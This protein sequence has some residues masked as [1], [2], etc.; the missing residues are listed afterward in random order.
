MKRTAITVRH[1]TIVNHIACF[2]NYAGGLATVE[3]SELS[4][5]TRLRPDLQ[6]ILPGATY[7]SDVKV[8][9]SLS[10]SHVENHWKNQLGAAK[11]GEKEKTKKYTQLA[12]QHHMEFAPF[13]TET[14]GGI[15][16]VSEQ[17]L[18]NIISTCA[19]HQRI[20]EPK[21]VRRELLGAI[22]IAIQKGNASAMFEGYYRARRATA[23]MECPISG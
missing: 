7:M 12:K 14:S 15:N 21:E 13:V 1:D 9:H 8:V 17:L 19:E 20:W 2:T 23:L 6:V 16:K 22:A 11:A 5:E 18:T 4:E 3:E 10:P